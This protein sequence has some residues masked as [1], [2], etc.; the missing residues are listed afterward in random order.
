[1]RIASS[2]S[3]PISKNDTAEKAISETVTMAWVQPLKNLPKMDCT[4][5]HKNKQ[6][7][8]QK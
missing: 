3:S 6:K 8:I 1:M 7:T 4:L 2:E 5:K